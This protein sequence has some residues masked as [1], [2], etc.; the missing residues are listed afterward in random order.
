MSNK[1][2]NFEVEFIAGEKIELK[3]FFLIYF[4][5]LNSFASRYVSDSSVC[6]DIVQE[7]F[8]AFWEKKKSFPNLNSA[9]AYLYTSVRNSCLDLLKHKKVEEKF[10][11]I[12][13]NQKEE[14]D[15]FLEEVITKEAHSEI[16]RE[17]NKLPEMGKN[18]L[19]LSLR[20]K[21]NEEIS[22]LLNITINTVKTHKSR[23]YKVLRH[24]LKD[25]FLFFC[26]L[27]KNNL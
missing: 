6:E 20:E 8:I 11:Q 3:E 12:K 1:L 26:S 16:Y 22:N 15:S 14:S 10:V 23:A 17:I 2:Q 24:N 7:V 13:L 5:V 19:L 18:V 21:S 25:L 4:P 27:R 9:K